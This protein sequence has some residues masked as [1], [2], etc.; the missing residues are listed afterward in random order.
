MFA[1]FR[2]TLVPRTFLILAGRIEPAQ[3]PRRIF[4]FHDS[5]RRAAPGIIATYV[6]D[7]LIVAPLRVPHHLRPDRHA[8]RIKPPVVGKFTFAGIDIATTEVGFTATQQRAAALLRPLPHE[9]TFRDFK[10]RLMEAAWL[11]QTRPDLA[12]TSA[13]L[14][15]VTETRW[16]VNKDKFIKSINKLIKRATD[17][18]TVGLQFRKMERESMHLR[19]YTDS[20]FANNADS[21]V[22]F[23]PFGGSSDR[24]TTQRRLVEWVA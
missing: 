4:D 11:Q 22:V 12:Y 10:S 19:I 18:P 23:R 5:F 14:A 15:Q 7:T 6:D 1:R 8:L 17:D 16:S 13:T 21:T 3:H 24:H 9:A 20:S 2:R